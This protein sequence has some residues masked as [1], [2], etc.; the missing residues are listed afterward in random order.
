MGAVALDETRFAILTPTRRI[1]AIAPV[2]GAASLLREIHAGIEA[3]FQRGDRIVYLGDIIG[4]GSDVVGA[5]D[6][7]LRFRRW[8]LAQPPFT[9]PDDV[10]V[11]RGSQEEMWRNL[12]QIQFAAAAG[13]TLQWM[14][15]RG[16]GATVEAYGGR[17]AEGIAAARDG[18]TAIAQWTSRLRIGLRASAGHGLFHAMLKRAAITSDGGMLF[19]NAGLDPAR[20]LGEQGDRF[21]WDAGGPDRMTGPHPEARLVVR[22]A[23]PERRGV[24][25][26]THWLGLDDGSGEG[27]ALNALCLSPDGEVLETLTA[28]PS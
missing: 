23:D 11:L 16:V 5:V 7:V 6:E 26:E 14:E 10:V 20:G 18:P 2:R 9:H 13:E 25:R 19:V 1:W 21:W 8:V 4:V 22:G 15:K 12:L 28:G 24:V 27:G 17:L 3:R